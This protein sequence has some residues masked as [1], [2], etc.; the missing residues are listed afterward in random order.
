L[1]KKDLD[2]MSAEEMQAALERAID[3]CGGIEG[4]VEYI[5]NTA[6]DEFFFNC[7]AHLKSIGQLPPEIDKVIQKLKQ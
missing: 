1:T 6:D 5:V 3:D 7:A 4:F 2:Q